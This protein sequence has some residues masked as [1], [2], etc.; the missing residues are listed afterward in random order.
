[1][2]KHIAIFD[3]TLRDGEQSPGCSMNLSEKL[4]VA[5]QLE[6]LGVDVI[7]AGFAIASRGDFESVQAI[8]K[9]LKHTKIASLARTT[10]KDIDCALDALEYALYPRLHTFI[11]TS[12]L[13]MQYKL[14]STPDQ[15]LERAIDMVKYAKLRCHDIE[16]SAEDASRSNP[17][18]LYKVLEGVI[19]AGATVIN[20]PDTV[21]YTTPEEYYRLI[22][23]IREHVKMPDYVS[24][25]VHCHNDLGLAVANSLSAIR[26]G[27]TQVEVTVNGIG[28]R[29]GNAALEELVM[30]LRTR[31][32]LYQ[33]ETRIDTTQIYPT[34]RLVS[35]VTGAKVARN[36]AI[37]GDNAF[38]HESGIHQHGVLANPETYEI[39]TPESIGL[40]KNRMILGK[41][42][43]RH[44]VKD[45]LVE[46]G[47]D[48]SELALDKVLEAF[49]S[50]ADKKKS[51]DDRDLEALVEGTW[52][53]KHRP[54]ELCSY[55][56]NTGNEMRSTATVSIMASGERKES[57]A[58][59]EGP[60]DAAFKALDS[61]VTHHG[62]LE[63]YQIQAITEGEDAQGEARVTLRFNQESV[64]VKA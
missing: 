19:K 32:D 21:G 1:M 15:V 64:M 42:S 6:K 25:S 3:T 9:T 59:G 30:S 27:A 11:A 4:L 53:E 23:G 48:L 14:K 41:H 20:I 5:K 57:V 61:L 18:F 36:K 12:D 54:F 26:A 29:A 60:V 51:V 33:V 28:E 17:I 8:S 63:D 39:M 49:K 13:H 7:E 10:K 47:Y 55:V 31:N 56:I 37:V 58:M 50:L 52:L 43:G 40:K 16:F 34:S 2:A 46:M 22:T 38:A 24:I 45:R 44:A 35:Q 62:L